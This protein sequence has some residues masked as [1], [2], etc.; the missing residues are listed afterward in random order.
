MNPSISKIPSS[1][2]LQS[3]RVTRGFTLVEALVV[4]SIIAILAVIVTSLAGHV[5]RSASSVVCVGQMRQIGNAMFLY[6]EENQGRLPTSPVHGSLHTGQ[7][8]WFNREERRL[9]YLIGQYLGSPTSNTWSTS[10]TV[11]TYDPA[12]AWPAL[13]ADCKQG[14]ASILLS[15]SVKIRNEDGTSGKGSAWAGTKPLGSSYFLGRPLRDIEDPRLQTVFTE[16]DQKNTTAGWKNNCPPR[17]IH[18]NYRNTLFFDWH[19]DRVA[20]KSN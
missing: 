13:L 17:P 18:G 3:G 16:V 12:F 7:G 11:M 9:Q 20:V 1:V 4:I 6:S 10:A 15:S 5:R 19:V 14:S 8:P 2:S